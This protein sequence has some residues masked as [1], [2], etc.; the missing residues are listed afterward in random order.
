MIKASIC[1]FLVVFSTTFG[2]GQGYNEET[3]AF[4]TS[5]DSM[6]D[7]WYVKKANEKIS[8]KVQNIY[9]YAP[10]EVPTFSDS[11]YNS[12]I[13]AI[14]SPLPYTYNKIV[15]PF[16]DLYALRKRNQVERMLGLSEHYFPYFEDVLE[17]NNMPHELKFL[18]VIESALNPVA[19]S[20]AGAAGMWQFM[21]STGKLYHL[22]IN[23]YLDERKDPYKSTLAAAQL[24]QDLYNLYGDWFL[25]LAAYN[26][27][28]GNVRKAIARSG[29]KKTFWEIYNY[30]PKET[31]GYVPAFIAATYVFKYHR[32]HNLYPVEVNLPIS[33]DTVLVQE[34]I[35]FKSIAQVID[36]DVEEL[37]TLNPQYKLDVIPA[38]SKPYPLRLPTSKAWSYCTMQDSIY[39]C[40]Y[41]S[42]GII[43]K[44]IVN[45]NKQS[46]EFVQNKQ[47]TNA[48]KTSTSNNS[49]STLKYK[50]KE[51]DFLSLIASMY[52]VSVYSLQR[53]NNLKGNTIHAGQEL[54]VE[55]PTS[56]LSYYEKFNS[57]QPSQKEKYVPKKPE[58]KYIYHTVKKG[59]TLNKIAAKYSGITI[60]DIIA[61][62]NIKNPDAIKIGQKLKITIKK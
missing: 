22:S 6:M 1:F 9:N 13:L 45:V 51:G 4:E 8:K 46:D 40:Y 34:Q 58:A 21:P 62:N 25:A 48:L 29:G 57:I 30:L 47:S 35:D 16:I 7:L 31:R 3:K 20:H 53:L 50:V 15:K 32:E 5:L 61:D 42:K 18:A 49:V 38:R 52:D 59:E 14:E 43:K 60:S 23:S 28:P 54:I 37:R 39:T 55:V 27:G 44:E 41:K 2:F 12:R 56:K 26:C 17:K 33:T 10:N 36:V 24:L 19:V 11:V